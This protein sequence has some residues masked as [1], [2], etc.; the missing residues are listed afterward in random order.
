MHKVE[1][2]LDNLAMHSRYLLPPHFEA[3]LIEEIVRLGDQQAPKMTRVTQ[4]QN[5][6]ADGD[7][8]AD[9]IRLEMNLGQGAC[10]RELMS[11][12]QLQALF[13]NLEKFEV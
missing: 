10:D 2:L 12:L 8:Q 5:N 9:R 13:L 4:H 11:R 6:N 1:I 7:D 3:V